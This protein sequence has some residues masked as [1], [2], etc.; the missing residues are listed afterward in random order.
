MN[1]IKVNLFI[2]G[3]LRDPQIF[4]SV[5]GLSFTLKPI[6]ADSTNLLAEPAFLPG[7][8]KV[9]P[10]NVYF[11]A[12]ANPASRIEGT[13]IYNV[14]ASALAEIDRYEGKRY[15]RETVRVHTAKG[16]IEAQAYL[17]S[18]ESMKKH[19]GDRFHVNLIH[20]LW[21]RKRIE[22]FIEKHT[23]PGEHTVDAELERRAKRELLATTERDLVISHYRKGPVSDYFLEHELDRPLPSIKHLYQDHQ[24]QPF[25]ENYL[26][27]V[28]KQVLLNQLDEKI[29]SQFRF[30]IER[31]LTSERYFRRSK[32][33]LAALRMINDNK[34]TV[35]LIV[36]ECLKTMPYTKHDLIDYVK[37]AVRAADSMFDK[38]V[39]KF[40]LDWIRSNLQPGLVPLGAELELSNLGPAAV[41][42]LRTA[43]KAFDSVYDDFRYFTDFGLDVLCWKLGGYVDDHSGET[44]RTRRLGFLEL[45]PGRLNI[46]G[47]LSRPATS[48]IWLLN[49]LINEIVDFYGVRPHSLHVSFQLRKKQIGSQKILP[50]GFVKCLLVLGGGL[51]QADSGKFCISRIANDEITQNQYGEELV[52]ARTSKRGWYLGEDEI[53]D[54]PPVQ[55]SAYVQQ[56]KF[57]RLDKRANYEPLILCLKG[58]QMAYNPA[59][60]I[61]AEQLKTDKKLQRDYEELKEWAVEPTEISPL[62]ITTFIHTVQQGLMNEAHHRPVHKLHYIDW[63]LSAV[64]V[65][66]RM[67]NKQVHK[68]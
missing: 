48:D 20:E 31:M 63:A 8:R 16:T 11:Y 38:R 4:K 14:P 42:P 27:L 58:L 19:F 21:L 36:Q 28:V 46:A 24:A 33:M 37:Y 47:E 34:S 64:D 43:Q 26:S 66:L 18:H 12:V 32:S 62:T 56:Y 44:E 50:L 13:V 1:K 23:R 30:E 52:F 57:I 39:A 53:A 65:Q 10:D 6:Q 22:K 51:A 59:D 7:Y 25:I 17:T 61:T 68:A 40:L 54:K 67:F 49:K 45:A 55:S 41:E 60:Y 15:D 29:Q 35:D 9:T 5:S 2:Y 3:S